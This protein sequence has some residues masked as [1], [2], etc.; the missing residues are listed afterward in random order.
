MRRQQREPDESARKKL[1]RFGKTAVAANRNIRAPW[2][3]LREER[4]F[5]ATVG[6]GS[7]GRGHGWLPACLFAQPNTFERGVSAQAVMDDR[8]ESLQGLRRIADSPDVSPN[9][10]T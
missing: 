9:S 4:F 10:S 6:N 1:L 7:F 5:A 8:T 3:V 2:Q